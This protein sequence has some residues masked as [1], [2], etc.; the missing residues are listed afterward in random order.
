MLDIIRSKSQSMAVKV[1]FGLII[2]V[3]VFWGVGSF[4]GGPG[5][6]VVNVNG[7]SISAPDFY[8]QYEFAVQNIRSQNPEVSTEDLKAMDLKMQV[9]RQMVMRTM[10][11]QEA[12]R[13]GLSITPVELRRQVETFPVF[14]KEGK[15]D[16]T[17]YTEV[18]KAQGEAPGVFEAALSKD[19]LL[20]KLERVVTAGAFVSPN[21]ARDLFMFDGERRGLEYVLFPLAD[22]TEGMAPTEAEIQK[23]YDENQQA[24][25]V[26]A[27]ADVEYLLLSPEN[28]AAAFPVD[29]AAIQAAYDKELDTYKHADMVH[30][31]HILVLAPEKV[32]PGTDSEKQDIAA[33]T[34][35]ED[36][37][38]RLLAGEDFAALAKAHSADGTREQGGDLGWF[39]HARMVPEFAD[40][41]FAL[42]PGETSAPVRSAFGYHIIR[43]EEKKAAG[44]TP[45]AEVKDD[46]AKSLAASQASGK[47]QD[48]LD[49]MLL[50]LLNGKDL[51]SVGAEYKLTPEKTGPLDAAEL[52]GRL[53]IKPA[54]AQALVDTKS[55]TMRE[56]PIATRT[57]Y[58]L[59]RVAE[60]TP[61]GV[62]PFA[63]VKAE[64]TTQL[65]R[66]KQLDAAKALAAKARDGMKDNALPADLTSKTQ[67]IDNVGRDG[68]VPEL[69]Q[70]AELATAAFGAQLNQ[71]LPSVYALD[72]GVVMARVVSVTPPTTEVWQQVEP[73]LT[74]ALL[75]SKREQLFSAFLVM[76]QD[77][78]TITVRTD[79][80]ILTTY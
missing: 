8:R 37:H 71:W 12:E 41:A 1:A 31:R 35:I 32:E 73:M 24:F 74:N 79:Q 49:Q 69:G 39:E 59:T 51:A 52:A 13:T 17:I 33:R 76:L 7:E 80:P 15:F 78:A 57:G 4:T 45:L 26:P 64:I 29:D 47:L 40:A 63:D 75:Q 50:A 2:V 19:L 22:H 34:A 46:I 65:T 3:F 30:A 77:K 61:A 67:K 66:T 70:N 72:K 62:K 6:E 68:Y 23:Y 55:G 28:L 56:A 20:Q 43:V 25:G 10:L 14:Q 44:V 18:L 27:K 54:E 42:K 21:E 5:T 36:V 53:G 11:L 38:K 16:P 60:S 9:V 48:V 58:L